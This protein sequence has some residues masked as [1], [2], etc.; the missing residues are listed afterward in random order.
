MD[1]VAKKIKVQKSKC[2]IEEV[3]PARRDSAILIFNI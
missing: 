1:V 2:K 3:I